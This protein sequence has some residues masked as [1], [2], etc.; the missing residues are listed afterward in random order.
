MADIRYRLMT[1][2]DAEA[3]SALVLASFDEYIAPE[4]TPA[5]IAAFRRYAAAEALRERTGKDHFIIVGVADTDV[6]GMI[7]I[8]DNDHVALLFVRKAWHRHGVARTLLKRGLAEARSRA[9]EVERVTVNATRFGVRAYEHLG[10]LQ[11]GPERI[12]D[13]MA[14]IPMAMRLDTEAHA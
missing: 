7:E 11:T 1:A 14:F 3:V 9:P 5:G 6:V 2:D 4:Y 12:V 8:R 10:F 13:G